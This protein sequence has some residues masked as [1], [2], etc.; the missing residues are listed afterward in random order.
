MP[1]D[2]RSRCGGESI[3]CHGNL[4]LSLADLRLQRCRVDMPVVYPGAI[5]QING[6]D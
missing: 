6:N 1:R 3:L 4:L 5:T 2:R